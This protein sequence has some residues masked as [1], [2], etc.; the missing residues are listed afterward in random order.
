MAFRMLE[1]FL[2]GAS[3]LGLSRAC[4]LAVTHRGTTTRQERK[5][6]VRTRGRSYG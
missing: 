3:G 1:W 4:E 5:Y 6:L 2:P